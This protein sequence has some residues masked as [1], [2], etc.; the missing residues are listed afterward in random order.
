MEAAVLH[1]GQSQQRACKTGADAELEA[2]VA[3]RLS[4]DAPLP[5]G[6][7]ALGAVEVLARAR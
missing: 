5:F 2:R 6:K 1:V 4:A 7:R 3:D